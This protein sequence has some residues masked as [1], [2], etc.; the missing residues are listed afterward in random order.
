MK[1]TTAGTPETFE[2]PVG[3]STSPAIGVAADTLTTAGTP[4]MSTALK[5]TAAPRTLAI[6][7]TI[8]RTQLGKPTAAIT[9]ATAI[10]V[11]K[12]RTAPPLYEGKSITRAMWE[13]V[14]PEN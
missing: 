8:A 4:G 13:G 10:K 1:P 5:T 6:A 2:K 11:N 3:E 9:S 12:L 14:D 7:E